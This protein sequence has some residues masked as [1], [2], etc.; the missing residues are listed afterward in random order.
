MT[1]N[2]IKAVKT[3]LLLLV[4]L[5]AIMTIFFYTAKKEVFEI[6]Q[7]TVPSS[8]QKEKDV[9]WDRLQGLEDDERVGVRVNGARAIAEVMR[10]DAKRQQGLSGREALGESE[11]MLFIFEHE[12]AQS[13]WNKDMKFPIDVLWLA[14]GAVV[15]MSPLPAYDGTTPVIITSPTPIDVVLEVPGG[16]AQKHN[17]VV[18]NTINIYETQ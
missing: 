2:N 11:G 1:G 3:F 10:S 14:Q 5:G 15:G 17:I 4:F 8:S 7:V 6:A 12:E 18:G 16:F 13:F 9:A